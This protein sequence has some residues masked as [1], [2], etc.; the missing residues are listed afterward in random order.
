MLLFQVSV[1]FSFALAPI[2]LT[3]WK[4]ELREAVKAAGEF[5]QAHPQS[6]HIKTFSVTR[7]GG[8]DHYQE[9]GNPVGSFDNAGLTMYDF[10]INAHHN[11]GCIGCLYAA[12][13]EEAQTAANKMAAIA[14]GTAEID[15]S[16]FEKTLLAVKEAKE[17]RNAVQ[18]LKAERRARYYAKNYDFTPEG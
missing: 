3:I 16:S 13:Y 7:V 5:V 12:S 17:K 14:G 10:T 4:E 6:S 1:Y 8:K 2:Q 15:L 11:S 9:I 18:Q